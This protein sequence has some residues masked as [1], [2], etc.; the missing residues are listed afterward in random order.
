MAY[1]TATPPRLG[2]AAVGAVG[3]NLWFYDSA[4]AATAVR[5]SGYITNG[6]EL[7]MKV[8]D[9]VIQ[10]DT[11][12]ATVGHI[13]QVVSVASGGAADLSDGTAIVATDTD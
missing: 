10:S 1:S 4:D 13:Y 5:A 8:G 11:V 12:G 2:V 9:T 6:D 3:P 7:G